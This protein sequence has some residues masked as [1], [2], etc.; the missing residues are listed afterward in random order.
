MSRLAPIGSIAAALLLAAVTVAAQ[1][2]PGATVEKTY[3]VGLPRDMDRLLIPDADYP[4]YP[5]KPGQEAYKSVDGYR[6]KADLKQL[7]AFSLMSLDA[8]E[9]YWG[10]IPGSRYHQM[11]LDFMAGEFEKLGLAVRRQPVDLPPMWYPTALVWQLPGGREQRTAA[12]AV[13]DR[14]HQAHAGRRP[15]GRGC[16]GRRG[17]SPRLDG[18]RPERQGG[19]D[20]QHVRARRTQPLGQRPRRSLQ[21]EHAG[22]EGRRGR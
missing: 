2:R 21:L 4:E 6:I 18:P 16:L 14:R 8:G 20:L 17:R 13:P 1:M 7:T 22:H 5:L 10:R 15:L 12:H 9:L 11:A 19:A 3:G